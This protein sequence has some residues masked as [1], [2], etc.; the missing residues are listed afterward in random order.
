[1]W[2]G[3]GSRGDAHEGRRVAL[4]DLADGV[5]PSPVDDRRCHAGRTDRVGG[6]RTATVV[7]ARGRERISYTLVSGAAHVNY[8]TTNGA[9]YRS[10]P[11]GKVELNWLGGFAPDVETVPHPEGYVLTLKRESRTTVL[12]GTPYRV[13]VARAMRRLAL[14]SF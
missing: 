14:A 12:V 8:G 11:G 7:Y 10:T 2:P 3:P 1:V 13:S 6:R 5:C 4:L 9:E